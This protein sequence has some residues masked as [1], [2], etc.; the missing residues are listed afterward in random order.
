MDDNYDHEPEEPELPQKPRD[1]KIDE[2]KEIVFQ[3]Y[4]AEGQNVYYGR[5][6]EIWMEKEFFHWIT[7]RALNELVAARRIA[8][9]RSS[10]GG[11]EAR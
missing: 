3:R 9:H 1:R 10:L 5:Q 8:S 2:A 6:L 11:R 4:F 7:K